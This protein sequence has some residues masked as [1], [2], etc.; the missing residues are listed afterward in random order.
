[1]ST[2]QRQ[3]TEAPLMEEPF[4]D[5]KTAR[6]AA[7]KNLKPKKPLKLNLAYPWLS[8]TLSVFLLCATLYLQHNPKLLTDL[9]T[10]HPLAL[11]HWLL[12]SLLVSLVVT[13][14]VFDVLRFVRKKDRFKKSLKALEHELDFAWQSRK[15]I[16]QQTQVYSNHAD[17][18]KRFISNR[19]LEQIEYDEKFLHFKSIAAEIRH[20]GIIS[21]DIVRSTLE[22]TL[23]AELETENPDQVLENTHRFGLPNN[24][25]SGPHQALQ[26]M[27][28][29]WDLLD[30]ST[31]DNICLYI[32][33]Y[34]IE[35]EE[36][37]YQNE[38]AKDSP[39][40]NTQS[41]VARVPLHPFNNNSLVFSANIATIKAM[42]PY[43]SGAQLDHLVSINN[44]PDNSGAVLENLFQNDQF[45]IWLGATPLLL[46]NEN[47][48]VLLLENL[49]KNAQFFST[50][51]AYKQKSDRIA[52]KLN[53][54]LGCTVISVYNRGPHIK[55]DNKLKIFELG[56]S[57]RRSKEHHGKG[58]GLFFVNEIV[59]GYQGSIDITN[60]NN[61][62]TTYQV[63]I[64][65]H[66]G[67]TLSKV[68]ER[69]M[70]NT[71]PLLREKDGEK[72]LACLKWQASSA[73]KTVQISSPHWD[74]PYVFDHFEGDST[75]IVEPNRPLSPEWSIA[76]T[77]KGRKHTV[78]F[79]ALNI[80]G[81]L[82]R[83]MLPSADTRQNSDAPL[84]NDSTGEQ[85]ELNQL[86]MSAELNR[87]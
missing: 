43:L 85:S 57:T 32:G 26:A 52:I 30:L 44:R 62:E 86:K 74:K 20:N 49:V 31:A 27:K 48:M 3:T 23:I 15:K 75:L 37:H 6:D 69:S 56:F 84:L 64:S 7:E 78:T 60:I 72:Y 58:L 38:L 33:N 76:V 21:Y 1:M 68:I 82:F 45:R 24:P 46:G 77:R 61:T 73:V 51:I 22:K 71:R 87:F 54:Q 55:E 18:L 59:K 19:L 35:C 34:L 14:L 8:P 42:G 83:V 47:H 29:L 80:E 9:V 39:A 28:Y 36:Q 65:F 63:C 4:A 25:N 40:L 53:Q 5:T 81:T 2:K 41:E 11:T 79:T 66:K 67:P 16:Q 70:Q 50:K 12:P 17:K 10:W 13:L